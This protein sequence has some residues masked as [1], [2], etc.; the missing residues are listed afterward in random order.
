[1]CFIALTVSGYVGILLYALIMCLKRKRNNNGGE[2][3]DDG[4]RRFR[5]GNSPSRQR[6][7][8]RFENFDLEAGTGIMMTGGP[9]GDWDDANTVGIPH[10]PPPPNG[11]AIRTPDGYRYK[12]PNS[13]VRRGSGGGGGVAMGSTGHPFHQRLNALDIVDGGKSPPHVDTCN[14]FQNTGVM[15]SSTSSGSPIHQ[16]NDGGFMEKVN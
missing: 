10:Q 3:D 11:T 9:P 13:A 6:Q 7:G 15:M 8:S 1:V 14:S 4:G 2:N 16:T 5:G 12:P